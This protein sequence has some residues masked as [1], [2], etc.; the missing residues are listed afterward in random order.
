MDTRFEPLIL[1]LEISKL[2]TDFN[3][4]VGHLTEAERRMGA[5]DP[6]KETVFSAQAT[7]KRPIGR[8]T[9]RFQGNCYNCGKV[10]HM[11]AKCR[12]PRKLN[13]H[14]TGPLA[15]PGRKRGLSPD[16]KHTIETS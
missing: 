10:G 14:S 2:S 11:S 4:I 12:I 8:S 6:I 5:K 1:Q 13:G 3:A 9:G 7:G 15:T 16:P